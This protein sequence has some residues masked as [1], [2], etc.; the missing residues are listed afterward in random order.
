MSWNAGTNEKASMK[1]IASLLLIMAVAASAADGAA[2][3]ATMPIANFLTLVRHPPME[4]SW[5]R[6]AGQ[7][8]HRAKGKGTLRFPIEFRG[9]FSRQRLLAQ[10]VFNKG[11]RYSVS[12]NF[13]DGAAGAAVIQDQPP[14]EGKTPLQDIGIRPGDLTLSFLHWEFKEELSPEKTRGLSCRRVKLQHPTQ[15]EY[16]IAWLST[17]YF[18]PL[19]VRWHRVT[20]EEPYR[21]LEFTGVKK[22]AENIRLPHELRIQNI[23]WKTL[24]K[25]DDVEFALITPDKPPPADLFLQAEPEDAPVE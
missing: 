16:V 12:Q 22:V 15:G 25:F 11:E 9:L 14:K 17:S 6:M 5:T 20:E 21:T 1:T 4:K 18:T 3:P 19:K 24:V 2:D 7:V 13:V 23:G 8:Q 10:L